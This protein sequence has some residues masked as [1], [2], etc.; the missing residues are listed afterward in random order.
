MAMLIITEAAGAT[1]E[2][3]TQHETLERDSGNL[4]SLA[5]GLLLGT[6]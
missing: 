4:N 1:L 2:T 3:K 6:T 5:P